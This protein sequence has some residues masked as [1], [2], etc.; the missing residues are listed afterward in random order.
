LREAEAPPPV[1]WS[2]WTLTAITRTPQ[3]PGIGETTRT[4]CPISRPA[5]APSGS[6]A[7]LSS[8]HGLR[9][10]WRTTIANQLTMTNAATALATNPSS[11]SHV[12]VTGRTVTADRRR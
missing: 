12:M 11:V 7:W 9:Q 10:Y 8:R 4:D 2:D 3:K 5:P 6:Y 1:A